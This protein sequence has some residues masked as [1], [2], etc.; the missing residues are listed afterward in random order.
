MNLNLPKHLRQVCVSLVALTAFSAAAADK[1]NILVI[2]G[3]DIGISNISKYSHGLMGYQTPNIDRIATEGVMFTDFY[4]EQSCTAGR[5]AMITGQPS[6]MLIG[7]P[8]STKWIWLSRAKG[9]RSA[10]GEGEALLCADRRPFHAHPSTAVAGQESATGLL[11]SAGFTSPPVN[12]SACCCAGLSFG[13][14]RSQSG[15]R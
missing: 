2:M 12:S 13:R 8:Q 11:V 9:W 5:S 14:F 10:R 1:P 6:L 4:G 3:D 15:V 7:L